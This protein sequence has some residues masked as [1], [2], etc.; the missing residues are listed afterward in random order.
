MA[1]QSSLVVQQV[2]LQQWAEQIRDCQSRPKGMDVETWC[3]QNNLTKANYYYRLCRVR[4][5]CLEQVQ[6]TTSA[7]FVELPVPAAS[8]ESP[9][10]PRTVISNGSVPVVRFRNTK[11][12]SVEIFSGV[13]SE[14]LHHLISLIV[15]VVVRKNIY[16]YGQL[17]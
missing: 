8:S 5:V 12:L 6:G 11:G 16:F 13:L 1:T 9:K 7:A 3:A 14:I 17:P 2:R 4:E 15:K 10:V